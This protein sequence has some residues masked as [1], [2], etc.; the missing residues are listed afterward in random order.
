MF[1]LNDQNVFQYLVEQKVIKPDK[2]KQGLIE[3][4]ICK[5]FN[6][7]IHFPDHRHLLVKQ[8]PHDQNGNTHQDF[9]HEWQ[10]YQLVR[11]QLELNHIQPLLSEAI[12]FD[13]THA[14]LVF[15]Y[16]VDYCDLEDF[17]AQNQAQACRFP[18]SI[19]AALG[20]TLAE[21]HRATFDRQDYQKFL[22]VRD[23]DGEAEEIDQEERD[24]ENP[25][26]EITE[27]VPDLKADLEK[28]TPEIFGTVSADG[29]KFYELY[30]RYD[31]LGQ[32]IRDL[33]AAYEPCCLTHNDLKL[34]NVLLHLEWESLLRLGDRSC[35]DSAS[36]QGTG[37]DSPL[38]LI[39]W[40]KWDWGD[41]ASDLGTL[42]A[43]YLKLWLKSLM[44]RS[45]IP[46]DMALQLAPLP[47]EWVQPSIVALT[48]S[49]L[50]HF[51]EILK[52]SPNFLR[53]TMQF[54]GLSLIESIQ[55]K[56]HY[57]EPFGNIE[58]CMLQVAKTLLC[59]PLESV[60]IVFGV[61]EAELLNLDLN[62]VRSGQTCDRQIFAPTE[63]HQNTIYQPTEQPGKKHPLAVGIAQTGESNQDEMLHDLV[64]NVRIQA[65]FCIDHPH[66]AA[67]VPPVGMADRLQQLPAELQRNYLQ[68]QLQNYLYDIYFSGEQEL[69][70]SVETD[71]A[72][73]HPPTL[74]N[75]TVRGLNVQFYEQLH[76]SNSGEGYFDSEWRVLRQAQEGT[77]AVQKDGLTVYIEPEQ[78]L[79]VATRS[80]SVADTVAIRLPRHRLEAGFYVAVGNAGLLPDNA[81]TI[82][83]Y[84]NITPAGAIVLMQRLT[85]CL[86]AIGMPFLFKAIVDPD[87]YGR[88]DSGILQVERCHYQ[89]VRQ[90]LQ[91]IYAEI[92]PK[93]FHTSV[94]LFTKMLAP[95]LGLAEE[96]D[97]ESYLADFGLNRCQQVATVLL[98]LWGT[99]KDSPQ[100]RL[101]TIHQHLTQQGIDWQRPYLNPDAEDLYTPLQL[102]VPQDW[103]I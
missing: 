28:L 18:R 33:N 44:V 73:F 39:D 57:Y 67:S 20:T 11:S 84:F 78:H 7:L 36:V 6:L 5:N 1:L 25:D 86:N 68:I 16:R 103:Q 4:K 42:I 49:Y 56:L 40:E 81:P 32:A 14:I 38:R 31:S 96:P 101:S 95:G 9:L 17:Y 79:R 54:A 100:T 80:C 60:P 13:S 70:P 43:S 3:S 71:V 55:T 15:N 92:A 2:Q 66:Y 93:H 21:V 75:N 37:G 45:S 34:S 59:H 23:R 98:S 69:A 85:Q 61:S 97:S 77:L 89:Q 29:L 48:Q 94:P 64:S 35:L 82:E 74:E 19:A 30:Q 65:D 63:T 24:D 46:L 72:S 27:S 76:Q 83:L 58:I 53:R 22:A 102:E 47:L 8:E 90:V 50:A 88:Y 99:E 10:V 51:P 26:G 12:H 41:P 62:L 52:H 91:P 87:D